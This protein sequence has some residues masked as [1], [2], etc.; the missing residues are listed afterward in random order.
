MAVPFNARIG[1]R[2]MSDLPAGI[3]SISPAGQRDVCMALS[4]ALLLAWLVWGESWLVW[5]ASGAL[6]LGMVWPGAFAPL[7]FLW[8]SAAYYLGRLSS[9]ILLSAVYLV[10]LLPVAIV[11]R[12]LGKDELALKKW[13]RGEESC[14]NSRRHLYGPGD[15]T[16]P[17]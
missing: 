3:S 7:A 11:R 6:F 2:L 10:I 15:F 4:F 16:N 14:F 17:Y 8:F 5:T 9:A 1:S 13:K 12:L